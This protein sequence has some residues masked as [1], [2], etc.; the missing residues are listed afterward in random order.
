[1]GLARSQELPQYM[2]CAQDPRYIPT[3]QITKLYIGTFAVVLSVLLKTQSKK[4]G[5]LVYRS[6][7]ALQRADYTK[8]AFQCTRCAPRVL[9]WL[10]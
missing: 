10:T 5:L 7:L 2:L 1:M 4:L 8:L 9:H 3:E 6:Y